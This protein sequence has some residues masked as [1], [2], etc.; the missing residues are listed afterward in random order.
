MATSKVAHFLGAAGSNPTIWFLFLMQFI[1]LY[2]IV[3]VRE[4]FEY[5]SLPEV[6][7]LIVTHS[8]SCT[9]IALFWLTSTMFR[10]H[11]FEGKGVN[12][13]KTS[14]HA[15]FCWFLDAFLMFLLISYWFFLIFQKRCTIFSNDLPFALY[16]MWVTASNVNYTELNKLNVLFEIK[17]RRSFL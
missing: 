17:I 12:H 5:L 10:T 8:R 11:C 13:S 15:F 1:K 16:I 4:F 14:V 3:F 7:V 2:Y 9:Y 6:W